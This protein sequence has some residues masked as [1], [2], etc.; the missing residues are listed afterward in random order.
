MGANQQILLFL[1]P[2]VLARFF[3]LSVLDLTALIYQ[4]H[5]HLSLNKLHA[6]SRLP[7]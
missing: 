7:F 3:P 5:D 6:M 2:N 4:F 1:Q